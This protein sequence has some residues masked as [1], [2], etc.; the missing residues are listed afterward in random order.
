MKITKE[1]AKDFI[2]ETPLIIIENSKGKIDIVG[3]K[4]GFSKLANDNYGR[5]TVLK[6]LTFLED[7]KNWK[8][9]NG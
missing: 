6:L 3:I 4:W 7:P 1:L 2:N 5:K 9:L 8:L